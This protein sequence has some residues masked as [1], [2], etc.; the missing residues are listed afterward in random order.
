MAFDNCTHLAA[1]LG[2][3]LLL[4]LT[5]APACAADPVGIWQTQD[6]RG[7]V[8]TEH[9]GLGKADLCGYVVWTKEPLSDGKPRLYA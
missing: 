5:A 4:G 9:C 3:S 2:A 7:R 8:R 6:G 1:S